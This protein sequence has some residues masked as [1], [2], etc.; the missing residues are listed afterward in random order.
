[1]MREVLLTYTGSLLKESRDIVAPYDLEQSPVLEKIQILKMPYILNRAENAFSIDYKNISHITV[2]NGM[3]V[4]LGD[5]II[6]IDALNVLKKIRPDIHITLIRPHR[7]S[8]YV[9]EIYQLAE[10]SII[11][12]VHYM[13]YPLSHINPKQL[14]ID[15]GNQLFWH[16]FNHMEM[17][18]FFLHILG[19]SPQDIENKDKSN[20][21]LSHVF[22]AENPKGYVLF[23]PDSSTPL[24]AIPARFHQ[25]II[26]RLYDRFHLPVLGFSDAKHPHYQ[27]VICRNTPDFI[28]MIKHANYVY[29]C[30]SSAVHIAAGYGIPTTCILT[31]ILPQY[32]TLY[33]SNCNSIYLGNNKTEKLHETHNK[34]IL[35][36]VEHAYDDYFKQC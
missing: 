18:D 23:C 17:H 6:G 2:I 34:A 31:S 21:W 29:T 24:R 22:P 19:V 4:T 25:T 9:E 13:P 32:R 30:D 20:Q 10:P 5:S 1:M 16:D 26:E 28:A 14:N 8:P 35:D 33:Y 11:D 3:G 27:K 12:K 36:S 7:C 15:A